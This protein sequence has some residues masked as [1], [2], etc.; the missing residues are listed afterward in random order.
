MSYPRLVLGLVVD[1]LAK[2]LVGAWLPGNCLNLIRLL[3]HVVFGVKLVWL[4]KHPADSLG[5]MLCDRRIL[6]CVGK[7]LSLWIKIVKEL[8][9]DKLVF[10]F[11]IEK[12]SNYQ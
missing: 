5:H 11:I 9:T 2:T 3:F 10:A 6:L 8:G 1:K 7:S 4:Q 12:L